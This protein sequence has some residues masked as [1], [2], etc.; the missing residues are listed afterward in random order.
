MAEEIWKGTISFGLVE[1]QVGLV[2]AEKSRRVEL[3]FLDRRDFA[4]V[5]NRR[6]NKSTQEEVPWSEIVHGYEYE[7]GEYVVLTRQDL[8]RASPERSRTIEI[9][10][11]VD[12]DEIE[13]IFF[14]KPYY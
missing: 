10:G 12:A 6:Y 4:P 13:P 11:F 8:E 5:G 1:I 14:D 2:S 3:G 7:K 9:Q